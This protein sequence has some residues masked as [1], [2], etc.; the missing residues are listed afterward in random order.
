MLGLLRGGGTN[1][2][3]GWGAKIRNLE[4]CMASYSYVGDDFESVHDDIG[5]YL[6]SSSCTLYHEGH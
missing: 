3:M 2:G 5:V 4:D 1:G 6:T